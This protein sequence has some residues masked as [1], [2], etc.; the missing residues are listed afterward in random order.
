MDTLSTSLNPI[1]TIPK[2][3]LKNH[4]HHP[5]IPSTTTKSKPKTTKLS[6]KTTSFTTQNHL[7]PPHINSSRPPSPLKHS[8][9]PEPHRRP[10][11]GYAVALLDAARRHNAVG[12]VRRDAGRLLRWLRDDQLRHVMADPDL[13]AKGEVVKE[14][15]KQGRFEK[16][17]VKLVK[18]L[19][20]KAKLELLVSVLSE[21]G[22]ICDELS[23]RND[24]VVLF[25]CGVKMEES[26]ILEIVE[27]IQKVTGADK[28]TLRELVHP[29][30]V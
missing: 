7:L 22:R 25:P 30:F 27:R 11:T 16:H 28:V 29:I 21:F 24:Q 9:P 1:F 23:V 26:Q 5:S 3:N 6:N 14:V 4:H 18:L 10:S 20:E 15:V 19:A 12:A 8:N 17:L 2:S 13:K